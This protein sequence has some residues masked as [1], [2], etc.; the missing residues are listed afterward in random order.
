MVAKVWSMLQNATF[1]VEESLVEELARDNQEV[2]DR[3]VDTLKTETYAPSFPPE[4]LCTLLSVVM[5]LVAS[6]EPHWITQILL[7]R[8]LRQV[9]THFITSRH[10]EV[11]D[12][13]MTILENMLDC[14]NREYLLNQLY[15]DDTCFVDN[16]ITVLREGGVQGKSSAVSIL[17][18]TLENQDYQQQF[19]YSK[20]LG[21]QV[22]EPLKDL[23]STSKEDL[24]LEVLQLIQAL[25]GYCHSQ[26]THR[27]EINHFRLL[28]GGQAIQTLLFE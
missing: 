9:L 8:G 17:R 6:D 26:D 10:S 14:H 20:L 4:T 22:L 24:L 28:G 16:L 2:L 11:Q 7:T 27:Q 18:K 3:L 1:R 5:N 13:V 23:L 21:K 12:T 15:S 19:L 25:L